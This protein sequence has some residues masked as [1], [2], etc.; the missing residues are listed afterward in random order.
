M[1]AVSSEAGAVVDD[2][3]EARDS[4]RQWREESSRKSLR[5]VELGTFLLMHK[6]SDLGNEGKLKGGGGGGIPLATLELTLSS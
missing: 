2:W 1:E 3:I 6:K 5:A 4:L